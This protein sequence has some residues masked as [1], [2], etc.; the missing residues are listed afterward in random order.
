MENSDVKLNTAK[1]ASI[2]APDLARSPRDLRASMARSPRDLAPDLAPDLARSQCNLRAIMARSPRDPRAISMQSRRDLGLISRRYGSL[3]A[4][5][6]LD[7]GHVAVGFDSGYLVVLNAAQP[8]TADELFAQ[9]LHTGRLSALAVSPVLKRAA[10]C[11]GNVVKVRW[12]H[13]LLTCYSPDYFSG[14]EARCHARRQRGQGA[15]YHDPPSRGLYNIHIFFR[16]VRYLIYRWWT[17]VLR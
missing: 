14:A 5:R 10:T 3:V 16:L 9:R 11:G 17:W 6:W 13:Y 1:C 15:R 4:Y 12:A 2:H 7:D 8:E